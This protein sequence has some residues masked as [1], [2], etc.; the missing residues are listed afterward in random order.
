MKPVVGPLAGLETPAG[1][2]GLYAELGYEGRIKNCADL[3]LTLAKPA[4]ERLEP[5]QSGWLPLD[6]PHDGPHVYGKL[7]KFLG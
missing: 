3:Y 2:I 1:R 6:P 7:E 4:F 5:G